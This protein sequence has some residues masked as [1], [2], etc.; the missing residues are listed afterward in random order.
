[1]RRIVVAGATPWN[2][3]ASENGKVKMRSLSPRL[4][5]RTI[6]LAARSARAASG[7]VAPSENQV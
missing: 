5:E 6:I 7:D 4:T 2:L 1:M 3:L